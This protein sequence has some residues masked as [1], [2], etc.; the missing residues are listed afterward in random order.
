MVLGAEP[1]HLT[2]FL[3]PAKK[4]GPGDVQEAWASSRGSMSPHFSEGQLLPDRFG[5]ISGFVGKLRDGQIFAFFQ[6]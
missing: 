3:L 6:S 1:T 2:G 5:R 4:A